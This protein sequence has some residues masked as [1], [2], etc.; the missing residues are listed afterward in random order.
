[1]VFIYITLFATFAIDYFSAALTGSL[2]WEATDRLIPGSVPLTAIQRG[3]SG[4]D[5]TSY[6]T[7]SFD[8]TRI[9]ALGS[10][11]AN[12]AWVALQPNPTLA[13]I[14]EPSTT[15]R[16]IISGTQ[17]LPTNSTLANVTI[18]YFTVDAFEWIQDPDSILTA[19]QIPLFLDYSQYS[20]YFS[21]R[22][23][24]GLLP[25]SQWGPTNTPRL[26]DP[27]IVSETRLFTFRVSRTYASG[28]GSC[29]QN[30]MVDPGSQINLHEYLVTDDYYDCFAIANVTYRAG[31]AMCQ[32]CKLISPT[33]VEA[34]APLSL[35]PDSFT[36]LALALAP[37]LGTNL[38][39]TN[40]SIPQNYGTRKNLA[41]ELTSQAYEAAWAAF[42]DNYGNQL[43]STAVEIALPTLRA[44]VIQWRVYLWVALH[45]WVWVLGLIFVG[46]QS[47]C[48]HPWV[49][50]PMMAVFWLD[51][52]A[53]LTGTG[54]D[55]WQPGE[56]LPND[57]ML[58]LDRAGQPS[59]SVTIM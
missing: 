18:P 5:L 50:D 43:D 59:H 10:A 17:Y 37:S 38:I 8:Q 1:M 9:V 16:R 3:I 26:G 54:V 41:I 53:V 20:P 35:I 32:N 12:L 33:V 44:N 57:G 27:Q 7:N 45:L 49:E 30:Y 42:S 56:E 15:I 25:D 58:K 24:G 52:S 13:T 28:N 19:K 2:I 34:Q 39:F 51:T 11:S 4:A 22:G 6:F 55:P 48:N 40:Y 31:A 47:Q 21:D 36:S 29:P 23:I 14:T 46:V